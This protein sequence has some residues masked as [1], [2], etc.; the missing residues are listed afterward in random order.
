MQF[1]DNVRIVGDS[2]GGGSGLPFTSELPNGWTIRFSACSITDP[3]GD[4]TEFG[5]APSEGCKVDNTPLDVAM[6]RDMILEKGFEVL[7]E[8]INANVQP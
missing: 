7:Q 3:A 8:L 4:V 5:V 1:R 6:G 2:T